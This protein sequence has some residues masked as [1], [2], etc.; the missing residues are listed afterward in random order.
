MN[1][2]EERD[3]AAWAFG[4]KSESVSVS[5][6]ALRTSPDKSRRDFD[7]DPDFDTQHLTLSFL[8]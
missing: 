4:S 5:R 7:N 2:Q 1:N 3:R 8:P 6:F